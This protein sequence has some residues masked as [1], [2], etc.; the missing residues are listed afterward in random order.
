MIDGQANNLLRSSRA[1]AIL[2]NYAYARKWGHNVL[3]SEAVGRDDAIHKWVDWNMMRFQESPS[4]APSPK[5]YQCVR[6]FTIAFFDA[7]ESPPCRV[8]FESSADAETVTITK[9]AKTCNAV[10]SQWEGVTDDGRIVYIRYRGG[11]GS[12]GIGATINEAITHTKQPLF[13]WYGDDALDGYISFETLKELL[14]P[15]VVMAEGITGGYDNDVTD[16]VEE[17]SGRAEVLSS[18]RDNKTSG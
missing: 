15:S 5:L 4:V 3:V 9:L 2:S 8:D 13:Y 10:P 16:L 18:V 17:I 7:E 1:H 11:Y 6:C 14:P 12:I